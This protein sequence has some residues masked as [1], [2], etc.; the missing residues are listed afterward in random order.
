M[1]TFALINETTDPQITH[2]LLLGGSA[3]L[4]KQSERD[5]APAWRQTPST[6]IVATCE[7]IES[8]SCHVTRIVDEIPEAPGAL[9]YH[10]IDN[11][12]RP[13]LVIG[14]NAIKSE[15]GDP[16]KALWSAISHEACEERGN[17]YVNLNVDMP[18]DV[19]DTAREVCDWTEG[20][21]Y[22]IDGYEMSNFNY[23]EFFCSDTQDGV[24]LDYL[25]LCTK[26]LTLR[27]NGYC[28]LRDKRTGTTR[29]IFGEAV[30]P[31]KKARRIA[32]LEG[33]YSR[34]GSIAA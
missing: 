10:T 26:P 6:F 1:D 22:D 33:G 13:V 32:A 18:D 4:Q 3:A 30:T 24:Q 12:G 27:P 31:E 25:K 14:W 7:S 5:F 17:E 9:A 8:I 23:P 21:T 28:V 20:D 29:T 2:D 15:P 11:L 34:R 16:M 19:H